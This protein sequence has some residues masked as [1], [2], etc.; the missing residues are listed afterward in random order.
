M[1]RADVAPP[2]I[3]DCPTDI[4]TPTEAQ[5]SSVAVV[6][7]PPTATD[8][9]GVAQS[10]SSHVPGDRFDYGQTVVSYSFSDATGNPALCTF[11]V[12]VIGKYNR[13]THELLTNI[14]CVCGRR[15]GRAVS[16]LL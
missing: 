12:S 5:Q 3:A 11:T 10:S 8:N 9:V 16:G 2:V 6:W 15:Y 14:L 13:I 1:W 7:T 4:T